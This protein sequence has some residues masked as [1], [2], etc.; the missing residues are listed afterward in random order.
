MVRIGVLLLATAACSLGQNPGDPFTLLRFIRKPS[1]P[2]VNPN[3]IEM[4]RAARVPVD[5]LG[6]KSIT[7]TQQVWLVEAHGSFASIE[8]TDKALAAVPAPP[9]P[10]AP[11]APATLVGLLRPGLSYRPEDA[12]KALPGARYFQVTFFRTRP[13]TSMD[14]AEVIRIRNAALDQVNLDRPELGYQI[15][16]G[17]ESGTYVFLAPLPSLQTIDNAIARTWGHADASGHAARQATSK[18]TAEADIARE[19]L[20]FRVDPVISSVSEAFAA[21]APDFWNGK[22]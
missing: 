16:S 9:D 17:G 15:I 7:G 3:V 8:A 2:T 20:L 18:I 21:A 19:Q 22:Q 13:G 5:V 12:L 14:F 10:D 6:L 11:L 1:G 4:H